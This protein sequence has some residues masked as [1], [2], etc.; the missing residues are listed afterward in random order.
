MY[1]HILRLIRAFE[2][3]FHDHRGS[4]SWALEAGGLTMSDSAVPS[5][6]GTVWQGCWEGLTR[7]PCGFVGK[8]MI[9][10]L[11]EKY[12]KIMK[13]YWTMMENIWKIHQ[14][15]LDDWENHLFPRLW[16]VILTVR[17]WTC[18]IE[19]V[20]L[21]NLKIVISIVSLPEG[22]G[23]SE[24]VRVYYMVGGLEHFLCFSIYWKFHHPN[25]LSY[26]SEGWLNHQPVIFMF[27]SFLSAILKGYPPATQSGP[28]F[29]YT[30]KNL[31][32]LMKFGWMQ[33]S[34]DAHHP[35]LH[36]QVWG[37]HS[38]FL[39]SLRW[40][41]RSVLVSSVFPSHFGHGKGP[42]W[43]FQ[44]QLWF[45]IISSVLRHNYLHWALIARFNSW[46]LPHFLNYCS[47]YSWRP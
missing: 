27:P 34:L 28:P 11:W 22:I 39:R 23:Y 38:T 2:S 10:W 36:H 15:S 33:V 9:W 40:C 30:K 41:L 7:K 24:K 19:I 29:L 25:W 12:G 46:T 32:E 17:Y 5:R 4:N 45:L 26:F 8:M 47:T 3:F 1:I 16:Y 35:R 18:S 13:K 44:V 14:S 31:W 37:F 21:P 42:F 20:Y 6:L 43:F